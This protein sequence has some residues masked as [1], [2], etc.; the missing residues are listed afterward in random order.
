MLKARWRSIVLVAGETVL[1]VA[2]VSLVVPGVIASIVLPRDPGAAAIVFAVGC[3][4]ACV[5]FSLG[6]VADLLRYS[7]PS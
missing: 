3:A 6:L 4:A 5:I 7:K 1:L 2:A